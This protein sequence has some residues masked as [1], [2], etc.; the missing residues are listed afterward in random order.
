VSAAND[1]T[2]RMVS[3]SEADLDTLLG[4][5]CEYA[6]YLAEHRAEESQYYA[7]GE[8]EEKEQTL[9]EVRLRARAILYAEDGDA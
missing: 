8:Y 2:P 7:P 4:A 3:I 5:A 9:E 6:D 1:T